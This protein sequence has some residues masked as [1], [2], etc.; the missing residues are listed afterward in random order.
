MR[1]RSG[2]TVG[3]TELSDVTGVGQRTKKEARV[4]GQ[5]T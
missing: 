5:K 3:V 4:G 2:E 1:M